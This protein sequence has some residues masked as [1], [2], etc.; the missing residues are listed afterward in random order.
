[1]IL[2]I[3][4]N[5]TR[6]KKIKTIQPISNQLLNTIW[7]VIAVT[8]LLGLRLLLQKNLTSQEFNE[9]DVLPLAKQYLDP[10]WIPNDWY[11]NQEPGYRLLFQTL[12]GWLIIQY[13]FLAGSIIGRLISYTLIAI[14]LVL[15]GKQLRLSLPFLL[16]TIV[17][18]TYLNKGCQQGVI[19]GE[20]LVGGL[21]TKVFAYGFV[22]MA[23]SFFLAERY[24]LMSLFLGIATSFHVLVGGWTVLIIIGWFCLRPY[25]G[26]FKIK[27]AIPLMFLSY[28][29]GS[30][31]AFPAIWEQLF[32]AT[33]INNDVPASSYMYVFMRLPHHLNPFTWTQG[34]WTEAIIYLIILVASMTLLR[35]LAQ[36]RNSQDSDEI[37][38]DRK[39]QKLGHFALISLI[40]FLSGLLVAFFD[41]QGKLLQ[42]YPFRLADI[43]LPLITCLLFVCVLEHGFFRHKSRLKLFICLILLSISVSLQ[44][45]DFQQRLLALQQFPSEEQEVS[46]EWKKMSNWIKNNTPQNAVIISPPVELPNFSWLTERATIAKYKLFSQTKTRLIEQYKRWDDLSGNTLSDSFVNGVLQGDTRTILTS[47]YNNLTTAQAE[48]LMKKYHA[49]YL[50]TNVEHKLDF[51]IAYRQEP[52]ILYIKN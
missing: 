52:Y 15:I 39:Q 40:P 44:A 23:L 45:V 48:A 13:G 33:P 4:N 43:M 7:Q 50:L 46:L 24:I 8:L 51:S 11:L 3:K 38:R 32:V 16:L 26:L 27:K 34:Q 12:V 1:M 2:T 28:I 20:C 9:V 36:K 35:Y 6:L 30:I 31:F 19:A 29:F 21:E 10:S 47:G 49:N 37:L 5:L 18:F 22:L 25:Q 41:S 14:G 17:L 42:Y